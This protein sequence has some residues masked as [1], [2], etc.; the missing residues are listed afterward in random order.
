MIILAGTD[1]LGDLGYREVC[2]MAG[3][4]DGCGYMLGSFH[5]DGA[6]GIGFWGYCFIFSTG[7]GQGDWILGDPDRRDLL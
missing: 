1:G 2:R 4:G 7:D 6:T 5:D 3:I